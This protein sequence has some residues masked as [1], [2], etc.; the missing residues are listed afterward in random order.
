LYV[1]RFETAFA[2][3]LILA[4]GIPVPNPLKIL[5]VFAYNFQFQYLVPPNITFFDQYYSYS[6]VARK[7]RSYTHDAQM[8][9]QDRLA[10]YDTVE[11]TMNG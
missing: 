5:L 11:S 3:Q 7:R 8:Y 4:W 6:T 10:F 9:E 1:R 2:F